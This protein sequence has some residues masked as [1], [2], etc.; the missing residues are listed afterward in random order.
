MLTPITPATLLHAERRPLP[1]PALAPGNFRRSMAAV[2]TAE[3]RHR[4]ADFVRAATRAGF[5][6][7]RYLDP[8]CV[9]IGQFAHE[10]HAGAALNWLAHLQTHESMRER[11][12]RGYREWSI[13]EK[14]QWLGRRRHLWSGFL[15]QVRRYRAARAAIDAPTMREAA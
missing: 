10:C 13:G 3:V 9:E 1:S 6:Y 11:T 4:E 5:T 8:A 14:R 12:F 7:D 2:C 15:R